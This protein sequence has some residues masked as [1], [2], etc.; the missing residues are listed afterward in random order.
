MLSAGVAGAI[1]GTSQPVPL[2]NSTDTRA[3]E[4]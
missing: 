3:Q 4:E 1:A 2:S